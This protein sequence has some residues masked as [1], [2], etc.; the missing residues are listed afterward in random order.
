MLWDNPEA[1]LMWWVLP[2]IAA[3]AVFAQRRQLRAARRFAA[4]EMLRFLLPKAAGL[5][6]WSKIVLTILALAFL[7]AGAARPRWGVYLEEVQTRGVDMFVLLDVSRSMLAEDVAPNRLD[8]AKSDIRDLVGRLGGDR[9]GLIVFAGA[10]VTQ[11]PLTTDHSFFLA[12]LADVDETSAPRGG[13]LLGDA[14]RKALASLQPNAERDHVLVVITDGEDHDSFPQEAA[15]EAAARDVKIFTVGL[16]DT[17]EGGRIP[18]RDGQGNL[19]YLQHEGQEHWSQMN[20]QLLR[21][22]A[23]DTG[24]AYIPARTQA[25]DLGEI[26]DEH[27]AGLTRGEITTERRKRYREQ[28]QLFLTLGIGLL[29]LEMSIPRYSPPQ[30]IESAGELIAS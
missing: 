2:V 19:T 18:V 21:E 15:K 9:V 25:Y 10:A 26:Y 1:L 4:P 23:L 5:R 29:L 28:F 30:Q 12:A 24:G 17:G 14:I 22:I 3:L 8:R 27:L 7:I 20:E 6:R 11:V 13:S 16:G